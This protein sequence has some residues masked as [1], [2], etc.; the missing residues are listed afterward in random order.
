MAPDEIAE[1]ALIQ[2]SQIERAIF[3][4]PPP[5]EETAM[6]MSNAPKT[7]RLASA[8]MVYTPGLI[9]WAINGYAFKGDRDNILR[10]ICE[11][12]SLP[13]RPAEALLSKAVPYTIEEGTVIFTV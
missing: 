9:A 7:Y 13:L 3:A 10:I 11:T 4:P 8:D 5:A 2:I 1:R 12:Y 6:D